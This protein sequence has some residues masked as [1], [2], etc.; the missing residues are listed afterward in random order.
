MNASYPAGAAA[1]PPPLAVAR[2]L[3]VAHEQ[4]RRHLVGG[5]DAQSAHRLAEF[6][7]RQL[8][9]VVVRRRAAS[10]DFKSDARWCFLIAIVGI[11]RRGFREAERGRT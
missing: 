8:V 5:H 1:T 4:A 10:R 9:R 7:A 6:L 11:K 2:A 3:A